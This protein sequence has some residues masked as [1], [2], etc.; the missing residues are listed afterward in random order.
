MMK[1]GNY[2]QVRFEAYDPMREYI[3]NVTKISMISL[4]SS[5][6]SCHAFQLVDYC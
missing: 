3:L 4:V 6:V 5:P 2:Y 1:I